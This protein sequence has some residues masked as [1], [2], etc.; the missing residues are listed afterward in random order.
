MFLIFKPGSLVILIWNKIQFYEEFYVK[1]LNII[2]CIR[3]FIN[4][5]KN[6]NPEMIQELY[7]KQ[8]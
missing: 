3:E 8:A 7:K 2:S 6:I 1:I 5:T 4:P